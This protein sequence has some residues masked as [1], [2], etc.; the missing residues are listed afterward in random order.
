M[1]AQN[2]DNQIL[3]I[4]FFIELLDQ[5]TPF[6]LFGKTLNGGLLLFQDLNGVEKRLDFFGMNFLHAYNKSMHTFDL[7][8]G[9]GLNILILVNNF[10]F[11]RKV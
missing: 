1:F 2:F 5:F 9:L 11:L 3:I 7:G 8:I 6:M 4:D 10:L